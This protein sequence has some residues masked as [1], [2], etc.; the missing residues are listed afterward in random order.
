MY[1]AEESQAKFSEWIREWWTELVDEAARRLMYP[2]DLII[3][4]LDDVFSIYQDEAE[5]DIDE[6]IRQRVGESNG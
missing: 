4:M 2:S 6:E 5:E 3:T 1:A